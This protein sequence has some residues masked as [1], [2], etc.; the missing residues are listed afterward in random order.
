LKIIKAT[1]PLKA[2]VPKAPSGHPPLKLKVKRRSNLTRQSSNSKDKK[3]QKPL[4][5]TC[6][7][8]EVATIS[9]AP[10]TLLKIE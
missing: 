8:K 4:C 2:A 3:I 10:R 7:T 6:S 5:R 9:L 1:P